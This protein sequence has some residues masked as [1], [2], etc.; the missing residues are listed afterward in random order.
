MKKYYYAIGIL[1]LSGAVFYGG[2][3]YGESKTGALTAASL[4]GFPRSG[5]QQLRNSTGGG[6][7]TRNA[8]NPGQSG[9]FTSGQVIS[10]D[11]QGITV[12][13][14]DGS[15]KIILVPSSTSIVKSISGTASDLK[16]GE[17]VSVN[18]TL[19]SDGSITAQ[20]VQIRQQPPSKSQ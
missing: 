11:N 17:D 2:M 1:L 20:M 16:Q 14:R 13:L 7:G 19:N 10:I 6:F 18:G 15:S 12:Q 9:G 8:G 5:Q 3:M 4:Q